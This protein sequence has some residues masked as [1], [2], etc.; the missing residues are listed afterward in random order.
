MSN[1]CARLPDRET[2]AISA[3]LAAV[4]LAFAPGAAWSAELP[5]AGLSA[6]TCST[7]A[8]IV[9]AAAAPAAPASG[10]S[11][12]EAILG[13]TVSALDRIRGQ[14]SGLALP[15]PGRARGSRMELAGGV[16]DPC[17]AA[18]LILPGQLQS[19]VLPVLASAPAIQAG[20]DAFLATQ[21]IPIRRTTFTRNWA[22]VSGAELAPADVTELLEKETGSG[23]ERLQA[24]NRWVNHNIAY[25]EDRAIWSRRDYWA[26][27]DE[28]LQL[29]QGD[30]ED[31]AIVKYQMLLSLGVR[32]EDLYLT[33][34]RDLARNADHAVL[35]VRQNGR[36]YLLDNSIDAIL[37]A[38]VAYDYRPTLSFN[39][40]SAW[41]H[42]AVARPQQTRA[43]Y[44]SVN[45]APS[46]RVIGFSR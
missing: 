17:N 35:I 15:L 42:S 26:T 24:V 33:L 8:G 40:E 28:T 22:R 25:A 9:P 20:S 29:G 30:C 41:L 45:A 14:Q 34:A 19:P 23:I 36:Y 16:Y 43:T 1:N 10:M 3:L 13:G 4:C 27:A 21:R 6:Q 18:M 11:K 46:P 12:S 44:L 32:R 37:P 5:L 39:S 31:L 2:R 7:G 38:H